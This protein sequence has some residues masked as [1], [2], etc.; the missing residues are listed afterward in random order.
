MKLSKKNSLTLCLLFTGLLITSCSSGSGNS[1]MVPVKINLGLDSGS[2]KAPSPGMI[3][4]ITLSVS[5]PDM[6]SGTHSIS[7]Q[8]GIIEIEVPAGPERRFDVLALADPESINAIKSWAGSATADLKAGVAAQIL[9]SMRISETK[10]IIPEPGYYDG[11]DYSGRLVQ[12]DNMTGAGWKEISGETI[13]MDIFSEAVL[14]EFAP[15][16]VDIDNEGRIYIANNSYEQNGVIIRMDDITGAGAEIFVDTVSYPNALAVDRVNNLLY[17]SEDASSLTRAPLSENTTMSSAT[18]DINMEAESFFGD[19]EYL[20]ITDFCPGED[21]KIYISD[22]NNNRVVLFDTEAP[23]GSRII[24]AVEGEVMLPIDKG[25]IMPGADGSVLSEPR[26]V[27]F[28]NG[29]VYTANYS[30][31]DGYK[32]IVYSSDLLFQYYHTGLS[33]ILAHEFYSL[34]GPAKFVGQANPYISLIDEAMEYGPQ[35]VVSFPPF[36]GSNSLINWQV[37]PADGF[38]NGVFQFF[39]TDNPSPPDPAILKLHITIDGM[40]IPA[41]EVDRIEISAE[42]NQSYSD[43]IYYDIDNMYMYITSD[44]DYFSIYINVYNSIDPQGEPLSDTYNYEGEL[45]QPWTEYQIDIDLSAL[46]VN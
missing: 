32:L 36:A 8:T 41:G 37:Y 22:A 33:N 12:M 4:G 19:G 26:D 24:S 31:P 3:S 2:T 38:G 10:L 42:F 1:G 46:P 7:P 15:W 28:K 17:Y 21:G 45:L 25:G 27:L 9:I 40:E 34:Y 43:K 30:G 14:N 39:N 35:R 13:I 6:T 29:L 5:G 23:A 20:Y 44:I 11:G 18:Y 16:D